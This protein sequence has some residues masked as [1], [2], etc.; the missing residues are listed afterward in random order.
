MMSPSESPSPPAPLAPEPGIAVGSSRGPLLVTLALMLAFTVSRLAILGI[1]SEREYDEG[2]YLLSARSIVAGHAMFSAVFSSQPPAFLETL[3]LVFRAFGDSLESGRLLTLAFAL[4]ALAAIAD[5]ARRLNGP[6][7]APCA[8]AA[9]AVSATF[10]DLSHMVQAESPALAIALA[11]FC[12]CIKARETGWHRGWLAGGGALFG[13]ALLFKLLVAP[14]AAPL[15]LLLLL[16]PGRSDAQEWELDGRALV[17]L[18]RVT[19]RA[20]I[21]AAAALAV[22][23]LPLLFYDHRA[24][25]EQTIAFHLDKHGAY[26]HE[27]DVNLGRAASHL[28]TD[29]SV[30][31]GAVLGLALLVLRRLPVALWLMAWL[32]TVLAFVAEQTPLFWRHF[33]LLCP[34]LA[35]AAAALP[36]LAAE[37]WRPAWRGGLALAMVALLTLP[38]ATDPRQRASILAWIDPPPSKGGDMPLQRAADWIRRH[39]R[40]DEL[41]VSDDPIAVYLAARTTA[42]ALCDTSNARITAESL[43]LG[44]A[45]YHSLAARVIV[46]ARG[47]RLSRLPGYLRWLRTHYDRQDPSST[48]LGPQ[49]NVWIR[50]ASRDSPALP[51]RPL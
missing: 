32:L 43:T 39:T 3:A 35:L 29:A 21:M 27:R 37:R 45:A 22:L 10:F 46:L 47:G 50:R 20:G 11:S 2:V 26:T 24:L 6:W 19:V 49:R 4:L 34:P 7:A 38:A 1:P 23:A 16:A 44:K 9:L 33:V 41:V 25:Y 40:P 30:S 36:T 51:D 8:V 14:L 48:G 42:P 31:V 12:A 13:L 28:W 15:G 5:L 18:R 17:L